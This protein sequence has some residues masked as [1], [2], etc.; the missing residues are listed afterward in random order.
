MNY[1]SPLIRQKGDDVS[2]TTSLLE[3]LVDKGELPNIR[4]KD[5]G[6]Q[7]RVHPFP[8]ESRSSV[9]E[10]VALR[11]ELVQRRE[12]G[13]RHVAD[14][15]GDYPLLEWTDRALT[16]K[17]TRGGKRG[18]LSERGDKFWTDAL[19][20]WGGFIDEDGVRRFESR[21]GLPE[22]QRWTA[23]RDARGKLLAER[24]L[25]T[26]TL[27]DVEPSVQARALR[28]R[29]QASYEVQ[30]LKLALSLARRHGASFDE[31]LLE[32]EPIAIRKSDKGHAL[33][34]EELDFLVARAPE[35]SRIAL[36]LKGRIGL[37]LS[38]L[39]TLTD[40]RVDLAAKTL[41]ISASLTKERRE[42]V[43]EL[44][45]AE[46]ALV[47]E[48]MSLVRPAGATLVFPR[49][50][51]SAWRREHF[52]ANVLATARTRAVADWKTENGLADEATTP[53]DRIDNHRLRHTAI[54]LMR[55]AGIPVELIAQRVG[56]SDGGAL[57]LRTYRHVQRDELRATLDKLGSLEEA[58]AVR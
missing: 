43:V 30:G 22:H 8:A 50:G 47:L 10:A 44:F 54:T 27:D 7:V 57:I 12:S 29:N 20:V 39:L 15:V 1:T 13:V 28:A 40:D 23:F 45:D 46:V 33:T 35:H 51:G 26:L 53:F 52:Y 2:S 37:R 42:K 4:R 38:E 17:R 11:E 25:S 36:A 19:R 31:R 48:Q 24:P 34:L 3:T 16:E 6:F 14:R 9:L 58:L 41:T 56:H 5:G 32:L 21:D 18:P 55:R 49:P